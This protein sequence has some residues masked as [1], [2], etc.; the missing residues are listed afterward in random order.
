MEKK[1]I[2]LAQTDTTAGFLSYDKASINAV[3]LR[4]AK[5]E[6][7]QTT[8]RF[9]QLKEAVRVPKAFKNVV[10]KARKTSFLY[11]NKKLIRVVKDCSH[12]DFLLNMGMMYSSSANAHGKGFCL[13]FAKANAGVIVD[14]NLHEGPPSCIYK[15]GKKR[16]KLLRAGKDLRR[17]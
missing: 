17:F 5:Q 7:L 15:L 8:A 16:A 9:T 2:Y 3:K 1:I 6:C 12:E 14:L 13:D 4:D 10:R 11:P